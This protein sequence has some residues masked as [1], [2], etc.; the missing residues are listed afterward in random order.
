M[1][2]A[3]Q[4]REEFHML[5]QNKIAIVTGAASGL[6]TASA[7]AMARE[8]AALMLADISAAAGAELASEIKK[9]GGQAEFC[10]TDVTVEDS[11]AEMVRQT[12]ERY[13][14]LD[15]AYNSA[16]IEGVAGAVHELDMAD[17]TATL[18][19]LI[20]GTYHSMKYEIRAMLESGGGAIVNASSTWGLNAYPGRSPYIAGKHAICGLTKTA[21]L[22][23]AAGNIRVNAIAPGPIMTP[24]LLRDWKGNAAKAAAGVPMQ[25]V[26]RPEEVADA[27][28]WLCSDKSS[29]ITG[30]VLP[31]DGGMLAQVG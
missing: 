12:V 13:G 21:A 10:Q 6:G 31:I 25:R 28:V 1:L 2:T 23:H 16:G 15:I 11:V 26:G 27:V 22:E 14:G 4:V 29:F 9:G 19:V 7:R 3:S 5:L 8:G 20:G 24:M 18:D 17:V 30:H